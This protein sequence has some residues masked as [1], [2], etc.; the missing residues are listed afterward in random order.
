MREQ[1]FQEM[2][3]GGRWRKNCDNRGP[4]GRMNA[5]GRRGDGPIHGPADGLGGAFQGGRGNR[6]RDESRGGQERGRGPEAWGTPEGG[7][8]HPEF[9][10]G[11]PRGRHRGGS[12]GGRG[13]HGGD[14][15]GQRRGRFLGQGDIRLLALA[16]IEQEPRHGY[17]IIKEVETLTNGSYAPSP[18]VIYPTLTYLE[19]AG[20]CNVETEGN[21]KR[22]AI[23][24]EGAAQLEEQRSEVTRI[25]D[26]LKAMGERARQESENSQQAAPSLPLSVETALLNLR[27]TAAERIKQ[28]PAVSSKIVQKLLQLA[29]DL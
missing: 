21:K 26:L 17:D 20:Q 22:Y 12:G 3:S 25:L 11:G 24:P 9:M 1:N 13:G 2:R 14:G 4:H 7:P 5:N 10:G 19:E 16:L 29:E 8:F 28:D 27:E 23:T 15:R 6:W 18:G